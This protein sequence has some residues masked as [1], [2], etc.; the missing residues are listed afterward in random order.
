MAWLAVVTGNESDS[1]RPAEVLV[2]WRR[3][4]RYQTNNEVC[5]YE[6][7]SVMRYRGTKLE[8]LARQN[9]GEASLWFCPELCL[10]PTLMFLS[11]EYSYL[12]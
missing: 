11:L 6:Q 1:W 7:C 10:I 8:A 4:K 5:I 9:I 12:I 2:I 3:F